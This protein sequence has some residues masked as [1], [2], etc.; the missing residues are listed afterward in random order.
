VQTPPLPFSRKAPKLQQPLT[1]VVALVVFLAMSNL[2]WANSCST[3]TLSLN[4]KAVTCTIP[5]KTPEPPL[6]ATLAGL[7]FTTQ[8]QGMVLIFDD[9][10][11]TMLSD[12]VAFTNVN[13]VA[14]VTFLSDTDLA[15]LTGLGLPIL[16]QFT[17]SEYLIPMSLALGNGNFLNVKICSDVE[18][19]TCY[20]ASDCIRMSEGTTSIPEPGTFILLGSG[21]FG[22]GALKLSA[23]SLRRRLLKWRQS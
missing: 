11:H 2:G 4:G 21:L 7:S 20:G 3:V 14:T 12:V 16:G 9:A 5:E 18:G 15:A 13:G 1:L 17:E 23:G 22:S 19:G 6:I 8:A 10:S